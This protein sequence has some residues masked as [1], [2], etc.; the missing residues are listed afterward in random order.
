MGHLQPDRVAQSPICGWASS[1]SGRNWRMVMAE[2]EQSF[3]LA[4]LQRRVESWSS[5]EGSIAET[6]DPASRNERQELAFWLMGSCLQ[7]WYGKALLQN[8]CWFH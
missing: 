8:P 5:P 4:L 1:W 3:P 7:N 2:S 6:A